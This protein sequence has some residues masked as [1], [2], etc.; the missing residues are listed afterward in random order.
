MQSVTYEVNNRS[1]ESIPLPQLAAR[2]IQNYGRSPSYSQLHKAVVS[3]QVPGVERVLAGWRVPVAAL[4][5]LADLFQ[6][7]E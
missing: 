5:T 2:L 1:S 4:P 3:G 7:A 6:L